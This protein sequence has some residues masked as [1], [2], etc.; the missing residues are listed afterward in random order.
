MAGMMQNPEF[1][2]Q[3]ADMMSRPEVIDQVR[4]QPPNH[5]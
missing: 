5:V 4:T 1:L 2:R 3:M